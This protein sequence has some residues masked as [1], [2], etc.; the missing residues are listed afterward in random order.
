MEKKRMFIASGDDAGYLSWEDNS[1]FRKKVVELYDES[2]TETGGSFDIPEEVLDL[3]DFQCLE[4][5][6]YLFEEE[7]FGTV[8]KM[9]DILINADIV[10]CGHS[11]NCIF[12]A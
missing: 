2:N 3:Y 8:K 7:E 12:I 9:L 10:N 1:D 5:V 4:I 11:Y 6:E